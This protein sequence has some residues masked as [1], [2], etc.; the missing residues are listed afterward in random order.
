DSVSAS[1]SEK[2][3]MAWP[4]KNPPNVPY[5]NLKRGSRLSPPSC[6][7][8]WQLKLLQ[9]EKSHSRN[10]RASPQAVGVRVSTLNLVCCGLHVKTPLP[11][12]WFNCDATLPR[13]GTNP[14]LSGTAFKFPFCPELDDIVPGLPLLAPCTD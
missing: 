6:C 4:A 8:V 11:R 13:P 5:P 2:F 12:E 10:V 14:P 7:S 1:E 3:E 9:R